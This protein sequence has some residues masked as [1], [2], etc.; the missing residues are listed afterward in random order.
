MQDVSERVRVQEL[1]CS[2]CSDG[3][4]VAAIMGHMVSTRRS[5]A[6]MV[7]AL[8][9][10][11]VSKSRPTFLTSYIYTYIYM[12]GTVLVSRWTTAPPSR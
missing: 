11:V 4:E 3:D 7:C 8:M 10:G 5:G 12:R 1:Q 6:Q 2:R 9:E